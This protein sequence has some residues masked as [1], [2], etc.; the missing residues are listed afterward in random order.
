MAAALLAAIFF[1]PIKVNA[2]SAEKAIVIDATTETVLYEKNANNRSLIAST[3]KIMTAI[4]VCERCNVL[5][6]FV[7]PKEAVGIEG[8][9]LY[10]REGEIFTVQEL[11]YGLMLRSGNDAA[12]ALAIYCGGTVEGFVQL[13]NDKA[14]QLGLTST[15]F[16][17][18]HGLDGQHHY[19]TARDLAVLAC[20]AMKNPIFAQTVSTKNVRIGDRSVTNHNKLLWRMEGA[21]GVKTGYTKAAGRIL[22]S[23]AKRQ[24]RRLIAVTI[25]APDDW[26]DHIKLMDN[27]FSKY[28]STVLVSAG[29]CL[30]YAQVRNGTD[31][32]VPL[33]A[34]DAFAFSIAEGETVDLVLQNSESVGAPVVN[35]QNAGHAVVIVDGVEVGKVQ[36]VYGALVWQVPEKVS[37]WKKLFGS[38]FG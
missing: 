38:V 2:I 3:T 1:F 14:R 25:N 37:F 13:M 35:G 27:G 11:L 34:A 9:S 17:N 22:V 10:L 5:D 19:S 7:V 18:P 4:I 8:S 16:E 24:G 30:G 26:S 21:E 28:R 33:L 32:K 36:M 6:R 20:Y 31:A 23:S 15:N 12:V 29:D